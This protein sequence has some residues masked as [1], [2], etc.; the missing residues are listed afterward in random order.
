[1]KEQVSF[2]ME[3]V[4]Q[5]DFIDR[6][7]Q[8]YQ[9]IIGL[10][11]ILLLPFFALGQTQEDDLQQVLQKLDRGESV[12]HA[13]INLSDINFATGTATLEAPAKIYLDKIARLLNA[14]SNMELLI[15]GHTDN[16]GSTAVNVKLATD[17][18]SVVKYYL[19]SKGIS[20]DRLK[21]SGF[22]STQPIADNN[23]PEGKA[24]NRRVEMEILKK[25][26]ARTV[27]DVIVL[28]NG[29]RIGSIVAEYNQKTITYRQFSNTNVQ[30]ISTKEVEKIIFADGRVV[31]FDV[32]VE[33]AS[34]P[35]RQS[36]KSGFNPFAKAAAFHK[37]QLVVGLGAGLK[38]NI[39][40]GYKDNSVLVPPVWLVAE[41]PIGA[42]FGAGISAGAMLWS[43]ENNITAS[44]MYYTLSPRIA[45]HFNLGTRI[46]LYTGCALTGRLGLLSFENN[47]ATV[48][49]SKFKVDF[50][51]FSGIR[52]Y[53]GRAFGAHLEYGGDNIACFRGGLVFRFGQ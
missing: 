2:Q 43:P 49:Q 36:A 5:L 31:T 47:N 52:Y 18:A 24:K 8:F 40:I 41:K 13:R 7:L 45:Y 50:S 23:T 33:P 6:T 44:Y 3:A 51:L 37:G 17:R 53:F 19:I 12:E 28:R 48:S 35:S 30:Q 9:Q 25:E 22:G 14:A 32:P 20:A 38:N 34:S 27:Q 39:G 15:N 29:D 42:N 1:M 11:A 46:D 4:N 10:A 16:T 21:A 26:T